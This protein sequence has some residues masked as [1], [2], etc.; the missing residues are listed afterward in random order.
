M[1]IRHILLATLL[2]TYATCGLAQKDSFAVDTL[3]DAVFL[4]MQGKSYP[5]GCTIPRSEL[6]H[7]HL[8]HYDLE[9]RVHQ[10]EMVCNRLIAGDLID[11][12]RKLYEAHY[13]IERI[14]M[15]DDFNADDEQSMRANNTSCFCFRHVAGSKHLSKHAQGL[16]VDI[17]TLYNPCVKT[18]KNGKTTIQPATAGKYVNR[19]RPFP[20]KITTDD[21]CYRLFTE[22]GF[23]WGGNWRSLKDYQHFE[24]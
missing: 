22:H 24:K 10:G 6:R 14:Q 1:N 4:R 20:Y 23:K 13:P 12:F 17:N 5:A 8:L 7:L 19:Q 18:G 16:A 15:I 11:I 21:L 9:G 2:A 3:T